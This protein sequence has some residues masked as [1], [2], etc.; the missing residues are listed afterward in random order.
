MLTMGSLWMYEARR[1]YVPYVPPNFVR[2]LK[3][4]SKNVPLKLKQT[5]NETH[6]SGMSI[7]PQ[8]EKKN[9]S[10]DTLYKSNSKKYLKNRVTAIIL[11]GV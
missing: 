11:M 4:H 1:V 5:N 10:S 7:N 9:H 3:L 2:N 8:Q 6:M